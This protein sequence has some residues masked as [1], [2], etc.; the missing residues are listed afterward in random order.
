MLDGLSPKARF[1]Y[2]H[3]L[4]L[5]RPVRQ[6]QAKPAIGSLPGGVEYGWDLMVLATVVPAHNLYPCDG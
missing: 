4:R 2:L 3:L 1:G 5:P 6:N